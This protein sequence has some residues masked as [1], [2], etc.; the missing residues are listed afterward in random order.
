MRLL[1]KKCFK[2]LQVR[3][4]LIEISLFV[5]KNPGRK[6]LPGAHERVRFWVGWVQDK[7]RKNKKPLIHPGVQDFG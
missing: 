5:L 1:I 6:C 4:C 7:E 3:E 2:K